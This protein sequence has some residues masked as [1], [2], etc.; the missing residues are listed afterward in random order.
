MA[1]P[2]KR[3]ATTA[4]GDSDRRP[5][6]EGVPLSRMRMVEERLR[7]NGEARVASLSRELGVSEMTIRRDLSLLEERGVAKR[8]HGGAVLLDSSFSD[9]GFVDRKLQQRTAKRRIAQRCAELLPVTGSLFVGGGTTTCEVVRFL[10]DR[11]GLEIFT[12][13]L[14]AASEAK[15]DGARMSVLGGTVQGPTCAAGR[16]ARS[17]FSFTA[18]GGHNGAWRR[19]HIGSRRCHES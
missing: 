5:S 1:G 7:E 2:R 13:N 18:V 19:C 15:S 12:S 11:S 4:D 3:R 6:A 16:R 10:R 17:R 14:A 8:S 9:P